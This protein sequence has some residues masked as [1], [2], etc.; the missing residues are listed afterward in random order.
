MAVFYQDNNGMWVIQMNPSPDDYYHLMRKIEQDRNEKQQRLRQRLATDMRA[1]LI[2]RLKEDETQNQGTTM[3]YEYDR[4]GNKVQL[5]DLVTVFN[6]PHV[7]ELH[8]TVQRLVQID[9]KTFYVKIDGGD[10]VYTNEVEYHSTPEIT[11]R[12][13]YTVKVGDKVRVYNVPGISRLNG[14][15][16]TLNEVGAT[17]RHGRFGFN[18]GPGASNKVYTNEVELIFEDEQT[19]QLNPN[20]RNLMDKMTFAAEVLEYLQD[21]RSREVFV[22]DPD[23]DVYE[24]QKILFNPENGRIYLVRD[25]DSEVPSDH[26]VTQNT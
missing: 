11:D 19:N 23:G 6:V 17:N 3:E 7:P 10:V 20:G 18:V 25:Y 1:L 15:E 4:N 13:G 9:G 12:K 14:T 26:Y 22:A 8:E 21:E 5:G 24:L 2:K 16:Q